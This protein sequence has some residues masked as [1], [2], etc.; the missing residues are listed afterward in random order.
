MQ[1]S[2]AWFSCEFCDWH[3]PFRASGEMSASEAAVRRLEALFKDVRI[4]SPP[5]PP[6][7]AHPSDRRNSIV[8]TVKVDKKCEIHGNNTTVTTSFRRGSLGNGVH[9]RR[10]SVGPRRES[11]PALHIVPPASLRRR[12]SLVLGSPA[13]RTLNHPSAFPATLRKDSL[14]VSLGNVNSPFRKDSL[15]L[16]RDSRRFSTD[17]LDGNRRNSWD[18]S[19]RGSSSSSG[20]WDDPIWE[21]NVKPSPRKVSFYYIRA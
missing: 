9:N 3:S 6:P 14:A 2:G 12:D 7:P 8:K 1:K 13:A 4:D 10:N 16:R 18:P 19:R 15:S 5:L 11:M 21:E 17:S 20:G